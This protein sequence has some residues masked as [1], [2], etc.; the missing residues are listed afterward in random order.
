MPA[1]RCVCCSR[2][3]PV[4]GAYTKK[5][6]TYTD[7]LAKALAQD[8]ADTF[9]S[10]L[11][12]HLESDCGDPKGLENQLVNEIAISSEWDVEASWAFKRPSHINLLELRSLLRLVMDL[13]KGKTSSS[14]CGLCRF[15]RDER[16]LQ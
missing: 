9:E 6:A 3:V 14:F 4:Q 16:S 11:S 15:H 8:F 5:S 10:M 12:S 2:H 1:L 13:V 7:L